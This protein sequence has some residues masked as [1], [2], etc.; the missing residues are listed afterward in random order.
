VIKRAQGD[1]AVSAEQAAVR[2]CL[3]PDEGSRAPVRTAQPLR[4]ENLAR[5][6]GPFYVGPAEKL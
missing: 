1:V 2:N 4:L 6:R 3:M 5:R